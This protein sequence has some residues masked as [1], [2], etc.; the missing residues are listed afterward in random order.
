MR[1]IATSRDFPVPALPAAPAVAA[2]RGV[3]DLMVVLGVLVL[4]TLSGYALEF[5]GIPYVTPGGVILSKLHPSLYIFSAAL[6]VAVVAH[7]DPLGYAG[8]LI[9]RRLGA[10]A[11]I[12]APVIAF[13]IMARLKPNLFAAFLIDSIA[14]AGVLA[15]VLAD[16][17]PRVRLLLARLV[18]LV[19]AT[20]C[21]L[22][23]V[24]VA[25]GWRLFPF[26]VKGMTMDWDYRATALFG[27]PLD[28]ALTV[29]VYVVILMT[30]RSVLGLPDRLRLPIILLALAS[31]P[32][33]GGRTAFAIVYAIAA[34]V[35]ALETL[36]FLSGRRIRA[37]TA[38]L[39]AIGAPL[40]IVV[41]FGAFQ[42]GVFDNFIGRF[43][44][45]SG[46]ASARLELFSLFRGFGVQ[47]LFIGYDIG[48]LITQVRVQGLEAGIEN[49][50][51]Q[52]LLLFGLP[53]SLLLWG[54]LAAFLGEMLR[55]CGRAAI[56]PILFVLVVNTSAVGIAGK[57]MMLLLPAA[58]I[59]ILLGGRDGVPAAP[60]WL[61][62][63]SSAS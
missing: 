17:P 20:H 35:M 39:G 53:L 41:V 59:L 11:L 49:A 21:A 43:Q 52:H 7:P 23:I 3:V 13:V 31:M 4:M 30:T 14:A 24:E 47:E 28:S 61:R 22:A 32:A 2:S 63:R 51:A 19:V 38:M 56:L 48:A 15:L 62:P 46:S 42:A 54:A 40:A 9:A 5:F 25:T 37:T 8:G 26:G 27:H 58:I 36:R 12:V 57:T 45:D 55:E 6:V 10:V 29:G 18:H 1:I 50:W 60:S 33:I 44:S 16:T 34:A